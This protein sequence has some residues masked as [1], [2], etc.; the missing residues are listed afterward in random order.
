MTQYQKEIKG[1][2]NDSMQLIQEIEKWMSFE[3][4]VSQYETF[5]YEY[6]GIKVTSLNFCRFNYAKIFTSLIVTVYCDG[7]NIQ[8]NGN[9]FGD[10][11]GSYKNSF[12][13]CLTKAVDKYCERKV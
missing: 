5:A 8:I 10:T 6:N 2:E 12:I 9:T 11:L 7:E 3:S 1:N 13:Q 4:R